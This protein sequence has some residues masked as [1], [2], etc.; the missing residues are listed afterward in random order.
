MPASAPAR[1]IV[2]ALLVVAIIG[3]V[4][5]GNDLVWTSE[6]G[7]ALVLHLVVLSVAALRGLVAGLV[8]AVAAAA[9]LAFLLHPAGSLRISEAASW[10]ALASFLFAAAFASRLV[11]QAREQADAARRR[12]EELTRLYQ[13]SVTLFGASERHGSL[14]RA[15]RLGLEA[16]EAERGTLVE[17]DGERG[18]SRTIAGDESVTDAAR[19]YAAAAAANISTVEERSG[20]RRI[21]CVAR[22]IGE[23]TR[24]LVAEGTRASRG[25]VE[26]V[27]ALV[28]L[29]A[30]QE[31]LLQTTSHLEALEE[32][33]RLKTAILRAVSHDLATP[34]AT[35]TIEIEALE[36]EL[37]GIPGMEP[38][39]RSLRQDVG[40]LRRRIENLLAMAR[41]ESGTYRPHPEPLPAADLFRTVRHHLDIV[42]PGRPVEVRIDPECPDLHI[43]PSLAV[44]IVGN[45]VDNAHRASPDGAAIELVARCERGG[46]RVVIEVLD[47]GRGLE[48]AGMMIEG[49][50]RPSGLGLEIARSLS[51]ASRAELAL[52]PRDG[53]GALARLS[54]PAFVEVLP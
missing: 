41:I 40:M 35:I 42:A 44:E 17:I 27:A 31:R 47:R 45:L 19:Q 10:V 13:L 52:M 21:V 14:E 30:E 29:A 2:E 36:R 25:A 8:A 53:G 28:S 7:L 24:V 39:V 33:D 22:G 46:D 32:S 23:T 51:H 37:A 3:L 20:G 1:T 26:S 11:T 34:L 4:V 12:E 38:R 43:D 6:V 15:T 48:G 50:S 54:A 5:A 16:I 9:G 18:E 49:D